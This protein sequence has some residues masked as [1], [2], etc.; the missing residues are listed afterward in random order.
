MSV[1]ICRHLCDSEKFTGVNP[2]DRYFLLFL[3]FNAEEDGTFR[4]PTN[5]LVKMLGGIDRKTFFRNVAKLEAAG[6]VTR[7]G[8][9][10]R[11]ASHLVAAGHQWQ[12]ADSH[13]A[14]G[15]QPPQPVAD[16]HVSSSPTPPLTLNKTIKTNNHEY[17]LDPPII[18]PS[19]TD[20]TITCMG[21]NPNV[22]VV[23]AQPTYWEKRANRKPWREY[24]EEQRQAY[25]A[26]KPQYTKEQ[27]AF[28][29]AYPKAPG[30]PAAFV[31][32]WE[33]VIKQDVLPQ[34]LINAAGIASNSPA[35]KENGGQYIPKPE[36]WLAGKGWAQTVEPWKAK[37]KQQA[38]QE[39]ANQPPPDLDFDP[40]C[41]DLQDVVTITSDMPV[42][43]K[44][45]D[46]SDWEP[47]ESEIIRLR[48]VSAIEKWVTARNNK[49]ARTKQP[50]IDAAREVLNFFLIQERT[51]E[52]P[53]IPSNRIA[54]LNTNVI[55]VSPE[56][57]LTTKQAICLARQD[58]NR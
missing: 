53:Y 32:A 54:W 40:F 20:G 16:S 36:N 39:D 52:K 49:L 5:G 18:P 7:G 51:G 42:P 12:V 56:E 3:A 50:L 17:S 38:I 43:F 33:E 15:G 21:E 44:V 46:T 9:P 34:E 41:K 23:K 29:E 31:L 48:A 47:S 35:F 45:R 24:I 11:L 10:L 27:E 1:P 6:F 4:Y 22:T 55:R 2:H 37:R 25:L 8:G 30:S 57:I 13:Q 58:L 28:L 26:S 14:S 19:K